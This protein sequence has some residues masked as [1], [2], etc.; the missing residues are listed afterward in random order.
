MALPKRINK[1]SR[2]SVREQM[3][4]PTWDDTD[5]IDDNDE[6]Y[7]PSYVY[8]EKPEEEEFEEYIARRGQPEVLSEE[9]VEDLH[10]ERSIS[11]ISSSVGTIGKLTAK[12][13]MTHSWKEWAH[14]DEKVL[15]LTLLMQKLLSD[16]D[17]S[18]E[19]RDARL[20][21]GDEYVKMVLT[22]EAMILREM[23]KGTVGRENP[24]HVD[25]A[26]KPV[27]IARVI[28]EIL[29]LGPL[30]PLYADES[31]TEI[32]ANGPF[33]IQ[34]EIKGTLHKVPGARFRDDEHLFD[35]CSNM[36]TS[37]NKRIDI[38]E[39]MADGRL[40]DKS[41]INVTHSSI[42]GG[43]TNLTIRRHPKISWS[44]RALVE[45][46]AMSEEIAAQLG[47]LIY[48]GCSTVIIGGTG[49]GKQLDD[50]TPLP[51]PTG[52]TTM[53]DVKEGDFVMSPLGIP[54][55]V[56]G[57]FQDK[58]D[59][60]AYTVTFSDGNTII[61]DADHNWLTYTRRER[62]SETRFE[63]RNLTRTRDYQLHKRVLPQVRTTKEI[64]ESLLTESGHVNHAVKVAKPVRYEVD[65]A[66]DRLID[67]YLL[68]LWLGDGCSTK[69]LISTADQEILDAFAKEYT[70]NHMGKYDYNVNGGF[71]VALKEMNLL[72]N[73]HVPEAYMIAPESV[74]RELLA[75]LLDSD[76]GIGDAGSI[77]F[78]SSN[79]ELTQQVR[80]LIQSLGYVVNKRE[81]TPSY[82]YNGEKKQGKQ[83]YTL[84][85]QSDVGVFKLKRKQD[86]HNEKIEK[87][88]SVRNTFRY[89]TSI[90]PYTDEKVSMHCITVDSEDHLYLAG[91]A[92]ITTHNTSMLNALSGAFPRTTRTITVE[93]NLELKLNPDRTVL[94]LEARAASTSGEGAITI[95]MLVRNTLRMRPDRI[96]VGEVRDATTYDMLQAMNTG[97]EGS[98]TTIHAN[99]ALSGI[100]RL[101]N[102]AA[103]SGNIDHKGVNSLIAGSVDLIVVVRRFHEDNSRRLAGIYEV[104]NRPQYEEETGISS[105]VPRPLWEWIHTHTNDDG[106]IEGEYRKI[107]DISD[108][109]RKKKRL[110]TAKP[111]SIEE[112]YE[113]SDHSPPTEEEQDDS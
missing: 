80:V 18:E 39:P 94:P 84:T 38:K 4:A 110:D 107:N 75:G 11:G 16:N 58:P 13:L 52:W 46:G 68:G 85:F 12:D 44:L 109:L 95:R 27:F 15:K 41:R 64:M 69:A 63:K 89:I 17:L 62:I 71:H 66:K 77:E 92:F 79:E 33:D 22:I 40:P 87:G 19:I 76:G 82:T 103:E 47:F 49:S 108:G 90:K 53:G 21:G 35:I 48:N 31:V 6:S 86:I 102:L 34:V 24:Y 106:S 72:G 45:S 42:G 65:N 60:E 83:A 26:D 56:T 29:G 112:I 59:V 98:M 5:T 2:P 28:N 101:A 61:A 88:Y 3:P 100:D 97:H 1:T 67:P 25:S 23:S 50:R 55:K 7:E 32:M 104:P 99:D 57:K 78:Y 81:R 93:D 54:T 74:R 36:L 8:I 51:T 96:V 9:D 14:L 30:E 73:K 105:V 70:I 10:S 111:M 20:E 43:R 91:D 113:L 37:V